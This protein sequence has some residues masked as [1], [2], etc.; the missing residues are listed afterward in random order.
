MNSFLCHEI[1]RCF[2]NRKAFIQ[3]PS[4]HDVMKV[5]SAWIS[6][7][8]SCCC[9]LL[10]CHSFFKSRHIIMKMHAT[11]SFCNIYSIPDSLPAILNLHLESEKD[12][13]SLFLA[14]LHGQKSQRGTGNQTQEDK[15]KKTRGN[16][17]ILILETLKLAQSCKAG[18]MTMVFISWLAFHVSS[19]ESKHQRGDNE[20]TPRGTRTCEAWRPN[21]KWCTALIK[22]CVD[23]KHKNKMRIPNVI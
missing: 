14:W 6:D 1:E 12:V 10:V 13:V 7:W 18:R 3:K 5:E 2:F 11:C 23:S 4:F 9:T 8:C 15:R 19:F 20:N 22:G 21:D 16:C 17:I